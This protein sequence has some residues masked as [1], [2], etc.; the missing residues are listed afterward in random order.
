MVST[1]KYIDLDGS[2][3]RWA[4]VFE[5]KFHNQSKMVLLASRTTITP[6][7]HGPIVS[8]IT[9]ILLISMVL[10]VCAKVALKLLV[11]RMFNRD[12]GAITIAMVINS[13]ALLKV[14]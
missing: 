11:S 10:S 12:D 5:A 13:S 3:C 7:N 9:W 6:D 1:Y 8:I 14:C 4:T 2:A